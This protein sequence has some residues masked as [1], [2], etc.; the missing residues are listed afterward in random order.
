MPIVTVPDR[1]AGQ[2]DALDHFCYF[3][4]YS[5][6]LSSIP[7]YFF[8]VSRLFIKSNTL[9]VSSL[10]SKSNLVKMSMSV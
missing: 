10:S 5:I 8:V 6:E 4:T 1:A 3:T 9:F 2:V 7:S